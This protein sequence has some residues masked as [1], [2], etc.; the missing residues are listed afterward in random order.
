MK[1]LFAAAALALLCAS[2]NASTAGISETRAETPV[3][4]ACPA[5]RRGVFMAEGAR[6]YG[7]EQITTFRNDSAFHCRCIVKSES[8]TPSCSQVRRFSLGRIDEG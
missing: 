4:Q 5:F 6:T 2:C 3:R 7:S 8:E 1:R